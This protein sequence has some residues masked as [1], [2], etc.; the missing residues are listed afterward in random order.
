[1]CR[2]LQE[3]GYGKLATSQHPNVPTR[4]RTWVV[5]A[6]SRRQPLDDKDF[7][8]F[9]FLDESLDSFDKQQQPWCR[10]RIVESDCTRKQV[11][12]FAFAGNRLVGTHR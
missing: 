12:K 11:N 9:F 5:A 10:A 4:S 6:T 8:H 2:T 1:M 7:V 3:F